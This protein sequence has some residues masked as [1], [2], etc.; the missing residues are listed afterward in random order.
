MSLLAVEARRTRWH[1]RPACTLSNGVVELTHLTG[2]GHIADF[3][4]A[5]V[6]ALNP[7][8]I[9]QWNSRDPT[10]FRPAHDESE[11]GPAAV[12]KLLS[13]I[14]GHSVC[15]GVF[16]M[17]SE[18][19]AAAGAVLHGEAGVRSWTATARSGRDE[20]RLRF[21]VRLP[22]FGLNF[23]R[24]IVLRPGESVVRVRESVCNLRATDQ[25]I[26][27]QQ[28]AVLGPPFLDPAS[29]IV[30]LPGE[31][32]IT[33]PGDYEARSALASN[34]EFTWPSAPGV[35]GGS[36][37]LQRPCQKSGLGFVAGIQIDP[38]RENAF[39]CAVNR[40]Q[41]L[42]FGYVFRRS[43]FPWVTL[44]E[45]N[46]ARTAPPWLGRERARAF[47]FGVSPLPIGRAATLRRGDLFGTPTMLRIPAGG[48][49]SAEW[50]MFLRRVPRGVACIR[51]VICRPNR[52]CL[53]PDAGRPLAMVAAGVADFL[54]A[55]QASAPRPRK[56]RPGS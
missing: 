44:W 40:E 11:F 50:L 31:R 6:P 38:N 34:A 42:A 33:D 7:F 30:S 17:P 5:D 1:G 8:S 48:V 52:L 47:E 39:V 2:G 53:T 25:F 43:Q 15:L 9:P 23:T 54:N 55:P 41:Q 29:C 12:G 14:A 3:H 36:L 20:G 16:G 56:A 49:V 24:E 27:W 13:G 35:N 46:C 21:S 18:E 22:A 32:G 10:R 4:A 26:Q 51:D 19:E 45:E 37:D 28:H